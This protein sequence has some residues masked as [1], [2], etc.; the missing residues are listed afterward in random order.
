ETP[1]RVYV[2]ICEYSNHPWG[3]GCQFHP[4]FKSKPLE[5]HPLFRSFIQAAL[6]FRR[7]KQ[8]TGREPAAALR[9][10]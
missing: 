3:L 5:P 8:V 2:E 1:D 4:E 10:Q 9:Q 6:E 7:Q